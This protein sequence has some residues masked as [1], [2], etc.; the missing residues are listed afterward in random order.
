ML[1]AYRAVLG[2]V[3]GVDLVARL[4]RGDEEDVLP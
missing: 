4:V 3:G 2:A 1:A